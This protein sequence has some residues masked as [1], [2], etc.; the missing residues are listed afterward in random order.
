VE[1]EEWRYPARKGGRGKKEYGVG[2]QCLR[3][4]VETH[5][6]RRS[7]DLLKLLPAPLPESFDT[8]ELARKFGVR[9]WIAQR[10]AY[11]LRACGAVDVIGKSGNSRLYRTR[12]RRSTL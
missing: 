3:H 4:I 1:I 11:C 9:R 6:L 5:R 2:D 12:K 10:I 7:A 8:A